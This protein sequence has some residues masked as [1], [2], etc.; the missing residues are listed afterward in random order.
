MSARITGTIQLSF[1]LGIGDDRVLDLDRGH[2]FYGRPFEDLVELGEHLALNLVVEGHSLSDVDGWRD[3]E[4]SDVVSIRPD[5]D[6]DWIHVER[7]P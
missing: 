1:D 6:V 7:R 4:D 3:L 5:A 2:S